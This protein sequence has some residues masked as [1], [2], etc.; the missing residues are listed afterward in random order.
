MSINN[1]REFLK[2]TAKSSALFILYT[3]TGPL[4]SSVLKSTT[5]DF[6]DGSLL[7]DPLG[8]FD[9]PM[10]FSYKVLISSG[11]IMADGLPYGRRPDG[12]AA[13]KLD[14]GNNALIINHETDNLDKRLDPISAYD[15]RFGIPYD[16][17]TTTLILDS[18]GKKVIDSRRSLTGTKKNCAGGKTPW[19]TWISCEE[20]YDRDHGYAFEINPKTKSLD[21]FKRLSEMG[22]F[23]REAITVDINDKKGTIYQTE[24]DP[25][26]LFY[27]FTPSIKD[28][29]DGEGV[30]E[31]L[32]I[33]NLEST[34]NKDGS[35]KSGDS[36]PVD[37]VLIDDPSA[38]KKR[39]KTQGK[40]KGATIFCGGEGIIFTNDAN[41]ES[42]IYFT[43][44]DGG[45]AGLGQIWSYAPSKSKITLF[46]E[47][48]DTKDLWEGDN[49]NVTP[50]GDLII[51]E[52]N[53]SNAC[54]LIGCTQNGMLYP[55]GRVAGN[56]SS[57]IAGICF[58]SDG[59]N[60][61]LN[62]QDEGK[63]IVINGDWNRIK[64]FRDKFDAKKINY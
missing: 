4:K 54:R 19:N 1:R 27:K 37:W 51:C 15:K 8:L 39:T 57:E 2:L 46:Y 12:M 52:D 36:F 18:S 23:K 62:I 42:V 56:S 59:N 35:I 64:N 21:G 29:L 7:S 41:S 43:C 14:D 6:W 5:N 48:T 50:W 30:L 20:T 55:L 3:Y 9:L 63:T 22:R 44:K 58:S 40:S 10:N 31:A 11:D 60:M 32:R 38:S 16:G 17:G 26:G 61:Y 33:K 47:S 25:M 53:D 13:F 24:D 45:Q 28:K 49:I 34:E